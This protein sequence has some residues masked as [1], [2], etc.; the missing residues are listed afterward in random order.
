MALENRQFD[1]KDI[2][3]SNGCFSIVIL[4]FR[5]VTKVSTSGCWTEIS[6]MCKNL[7]SPGDGTLMAGNRKISV[8]K[9]CLGFVLIG[10]LLRII[11]C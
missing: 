8:A 4:A 11:P 10:A 6:G 2:S 7:G 1:R 5:G 9:P 3:F